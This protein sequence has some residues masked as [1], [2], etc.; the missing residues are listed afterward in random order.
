MEHLKRQV[1]DFIN[2]PF[3]TLLCAPLIRQPIVSG[4]LRVHTDAERVLTSQKVQIR[5]GRYERYERMLVRKYFRSD[6]NTVDL[7]ASL[8]VIS[9]EILGR[10]K[11]GKLISVEADPQLCQIARRNIG[12]NY[13]ASH[14]EVV[15]A[16]IVTETVT[17]ASVEFG[18]P[19]SG[20]QGGHVLGTIDGHTEVIAVPTVTLTEIIRKLD[21]GN[22][23]LACDIE[24]SE[25]PLFIH[26]IEAF[27]QCEL[28]MIELHHSSYAGIDYSPRQVEALIIDNLGM[29]K[30]HQNG[31]VYLF[32][33]GS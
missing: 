10:L 22:F 32:V 13:P 16:A 29:K 23:Q 27:R 28:M 19:L 17:A 2:S 31:N 15:N 30:S 8:G 25:I 9:C 1:Y 21:G 18:R 6:L 3:G 14:V 33:R 11:T 5:L 12:F 24:G 4:S 20:T 26:S 7:G